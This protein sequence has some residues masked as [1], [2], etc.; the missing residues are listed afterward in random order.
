MRIETTRS[1]NAVRLEHAAGFHGSAADLLDQ[2][3][4][5]AEQA[6]RREEPLA[7]AGMGGEDNFTNTGFPNADSDIYGN[8]LSHAW[9]DA[10]EAEGANENVRI[11]GNYIDRTAIGIATTV[12]LGRPGVRVPQRL[13]PQPDL[14]DGALDSDDRQPF[15]K[16]GSDATLGH[17]R[18]YIFHNTMLQATQ[19][20]ATYGLGGGR[21]HRRHGLDASRSATPGRRTTSTTCGRPERRRLP[22]R[23]AATRSPPTCTTAH[24]GD[25]RSSERHQ[26]HAGVRRGPR[27]AERGGRQLPARRGQPGHAAALRIA[28]FND[29]FA[30]AA[31][32]VGAHEGGHRDEVRLAASPGGRRAAPPRRRRRPR[33]RPR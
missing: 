33:R 6:L 22:D 1:A 31:P 9:D 27:L 30:G 23:A 2:L 7:I 5:L 25:A 16:S 12:D 20:G 10:I 3:V 8:R 21:G 18:R 15:F 13:E 24:P 4:P 26:R 14:R 17:G 29:G 32:D 28:N 19:S 11:W